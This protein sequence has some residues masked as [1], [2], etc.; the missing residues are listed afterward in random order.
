MTW[1]GNRAKEQYAYRRVKWNP[2]ESDHFA[3]LESYGNIT[4]GTV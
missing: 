1:L 2:G 4:S 3:E